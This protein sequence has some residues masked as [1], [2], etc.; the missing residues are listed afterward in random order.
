V[1]DEQLQRVVWHAAFRQERD[2]DPL[3]EQVLEADHAQSRQAAMMTCVAASQ[4]FL[5]PTNRAI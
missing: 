1:I 5:L 4:T 3:A 2:A